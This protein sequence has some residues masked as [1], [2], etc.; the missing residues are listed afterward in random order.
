ML[1]LPAFAEHVP[2]TSVI[3][4]PPEGFVLSE[5]FAGFVKESTGS[6]INVSELPGQYK[7]FSINF[8]TREHLLA[9]GMKL[10][11]RESTQVDGHA[12]LLLH[13]GQFLDGTLYKKWILGIDRYGDTTLII[14]KYPET[15][16]R[17]QGESLK[18]AILGLT[19]IKN[20]DPI[21]KLPFSVEPVVPFNVARVIGKI[22]FLTPGGQFPLEDKDTPFM[23]LGSHISKDLEVSDQKALA[24]RTIAKTGVVENVSAIQSNPITIGKL[25]GWAT[26]ARGVNKDTSTPFSIFQVILFDRPLYC[27]IQGVAPSKEKSTYL[28]IFNKIAETFKI[29]ENLITT[30]VQ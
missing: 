26:M 11:S 16:D 1:T 9:H 24:E 27:F 18:A 21:N 13:V 5:H 6:S 14:A 29:K 12:A 22:L 4:N 17:Q 25:S 3:I 8:S 15:Y 20:S 23:I 7:E 28:P 30:N 19:Y 10:I 2:G